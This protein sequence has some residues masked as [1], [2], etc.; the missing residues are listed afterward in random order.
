MKVI[1]VESLTNAEPKMTPDGVNCNL[2]TMLSHQTEVQQ[3]IKM[4]P[5]FFSIKTL[6]TMY[7]QTI[8]SQQELK[9]Y[10]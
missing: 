7:K 5:D 4:S 3:N 8:Y 1:V 9:Q 6:I 2:F 10:Y